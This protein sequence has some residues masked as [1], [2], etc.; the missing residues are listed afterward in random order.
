MT[1]PE[2][3]ELLDELY[4]AIKRYV[5]LPDDHAAVGVTLWIATTHALPAFDFAPR[6][7]IGSPQKRCG[8]TR[9]LDV[10][11]H[12]AHKPLATSNATV[13]AL[14]R[15]IGGGHPPCLIFDE[16]DTV[17]GSKR[18]AEQHE[19]L[20]NL[21]NNGFQRGRETLRCVGPN[22]VPQKFPI[23][24][25]AAL[26]GIG[27][28]PDTITDRAVNLTMRRRAP[29]ETVKPFRLRR[30]GPKLHDLQVRLASWAASKLDVLTEAEPDMPVE[31]READ[32]WEPLVALADAAGGRWPELARQ[33]C[34]ALTA[35]AAA[36]D[37]SQSLGVALLVD[38]RDVFSARAVSF[39]SSAD[40][41]AAL[42][43]VD[44]S[45]WSDF[46]LNP[47]KLAARLKPFGVTSTRDSAGDVRG[48]RLEDFCDPF[49][50][51]LRQEASECVS[52]GSEQRKPSDTEMS[53]D[54]SI[55]QTEITC[56][57]ISAVQQ[58]FLTVLTGSDGEARKSGPDGVASY[59]TVRAGDRHPP[60]RRQRTRGKNR[61][62]QQTPAQGETA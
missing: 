4:E 17:F 23:F 22:Q 12:T 41:V 42:Q 2:G 53:S 35:G 36:A 21:F 62:A 33:A 3:T 15:S 28:L 61:A 46:E 52:T 8:K 5:I 38:I 19:D 37:E 34:K 56:Q 49:E 51:Y 50:R 48:Y 40:L 9:L 18:L 6:L 14:F 54:T 39:I 59:D 30:D 43:K 27:T 20:R 47:R 29:G 60:R 1:N 24:A 26:A 25:M 57:N 11:E 32:T 31:D 58:P 16:A 55:R 7:A 44:E 45:P 10:I 13:A